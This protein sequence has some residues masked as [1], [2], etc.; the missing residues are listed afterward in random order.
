MSIRNQN[1]ETV[2]MLAAER[3][4]LA[5]MKVLLDRQVDVNAISNP[6]ETALALAAGATQ[7]IQ[8]SEDDET[9]GN[10]EYEAGEIREQRPLPETQILAAIDLLL[11]AGADPNLPNC[12]AI[13]LGAA[14]SRGYLQ[15]MQRL[16]DAGARID[17]QTDDGDTALDL[18]DLYDQTRA[19][20]WLKQQSGNLDWKNR[21]DRDDDEY[22]EDDDEDQYWGPELLKPDFSTAAQTPEFQQAVADLAELCSSKAVPMHAGSRLV[23]SPCRQQTSSPNRDRNHTTAIFRTRLFPSTNPTIIIAMGRTSFAFYRQPINTKS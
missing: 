12:A 14:A 6:G 13:P 22:D 5:L 23:W 18:A 2:L 8:V 16:V 7:W 19:L 1:N 3:C 10:R 15:A 21:W 9:Q 17:L 11:A 4:H 20:E